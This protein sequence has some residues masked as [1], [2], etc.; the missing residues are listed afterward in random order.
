MNE[1]YASLYNRYARAFLGVFGTEVDV[2]LCERVAHASELL[3]AHRNWLYFFDLPAVRAEQIHRMV[4]LLLERLSLPVFFE[5]LLLLMMARK[6]I[7]LLPET[8]G[9]ISRNQL[10][11]LNVM[12][13]SVCSYPMLKEQQVDELRGF[14]SHTSCAKVVLD[15]TEDSSLICGIRAQSMTRLWEHS[16]KKK[17]HTSLQVC[18]AKGI[19]LSTTLD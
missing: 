11:Y 13:F 8:L 7:W 9:V 5:R 14:L 16:I 15:I 12:H 3:K 17:L 2:E 10:H 19:R 18:M 4:H 1:E 6:R